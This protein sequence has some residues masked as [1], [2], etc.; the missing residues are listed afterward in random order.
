[1]RFFVRLPDAQAVPELR[2]IV[3]NAEGLQPL[4]DTDYAGTLMVSTERFRSL[5]PYAVLFCHPD[6]PCGALIVNENFY[7]FR[8]RDVWIPPAV[9]I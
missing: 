1:M 5:R 8:E 9:Y 4:G 3:V 2:V 6:F 7:R